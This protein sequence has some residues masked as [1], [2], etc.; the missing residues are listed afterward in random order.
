MNKVKRPTFKIGDRVAE[1]PKSHAILAVREESREIVNKNRSQRRG[2]VVDVFYKKKVTRNIIDPKIT[3]ELM[4]QVKQWVEEGQSFRSIASKVGVAKP[5]S[6]SNWLK[7]IELEGEAAAFASK[8]V[9]EDPYVSVQWDHLKS[10]MVHAQMRLC[11][12][13]ELDALSTNT[14]ESIFN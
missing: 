9:V 4:Q 7:R 2:I 10:P 1:R 3:P 6:L 12:E 8:R 11:L 13:S 14:I 5:G